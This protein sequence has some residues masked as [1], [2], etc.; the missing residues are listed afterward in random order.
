M[1]DRITRPS[2]RLAG[3]LPDGNLS[4]LE[5]TAGQQLG[6]SPPP[7]YALIRLTRTRLVEEDD[8][9]GAETAV[10][11]V[12]ALEV[13]TTIPALAQPGMTVEDLMIALRA[14]RTGDNPIPFDTDNADRDDLLMQF[15]DWQQ[16]RG[17]TDTEAADEWRGRFG[18]GG[19]T[20]RDAPPVQLREFLAYQ[21]EAA[22]DE[23]AD[24]DLAD[25]SADGVDLAAAGDGRTA[26][27]VHDAAV[28]TAEEPGT[29]PGDALAKV[30]SRR[31][32]R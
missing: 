10:L 18:D 4:N 15:R 7:V 11:K 23:A 8:N 5:G 30:R 20:W 16:A 22:D 12:R 3:G 31:A 24:P 2:V 27:D 1:A 17:L 13:L 19:G 14:E 26:A 32:A 6:G 29:D 25:G 28:V 21:R 9:D